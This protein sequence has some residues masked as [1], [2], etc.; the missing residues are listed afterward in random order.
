MSNMTK[1]IT[2]IGS[3]GAGKSVM[4]A[5]IFAELKIMGYSAELVKEIAKDLIY[6][7]KIE[8]LKDQYQ[9]ILES[10]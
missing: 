1:V 2:F 10:F 6:E 7:N 4:N 9:T 8:I 5:M 3:P